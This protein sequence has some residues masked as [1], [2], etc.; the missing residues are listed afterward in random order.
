MTGFFNRL[1]AGELLKKTFQC[2]QDPR[3]YGKTNIINLEII[4]NGE[5]KFLQQQ[6]C[7]FGHR[8]LPVWASCV[9]SELGRILH[10]E[11]I[12]VIG[13]LID[14][15]LFHGPAKDGAAALQAQLEEADSIMTSLG[16]PPNDKGQN[17]STRVVFS[18]ITI[19][20]VEGVFDIDEDQ[21]T[22]VIQR[23]RE[24]L[25]YQYC[26]VKTLESVNGS[27]GWLCFVIH[28]GRCRR[29]NLQE[30]CN[31]TLKQVSVT[32]P[33]RK[34]IAWWIDILDRKAYQP[35]PIWFRDEI[36]P[37]LLIPSDTSGDHGFGFCS[38]GFHVTGSWR[39]SL[40]PVISNDMFVKELLPVTIAGCC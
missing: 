40:A 18:G 7:M 21:R 39:A 3:T 32:R 10:N 9:S 17:P 31:S 16:L 35:S 5:A 22:Y 37:S 29:D 23:L 13:I 34:Q 2:F 15:I 4:K 14:D 24:I 1:T 28:H 11:C 38:A 6:S 26:P 33:M 19:D 36:Q 27:L 25:E 8:Q 12:R 20:S 30:A